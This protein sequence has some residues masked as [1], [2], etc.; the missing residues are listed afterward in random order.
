MSARS[1]GTTG[2]RIERLVKTE[3]GPAIRLLHKRASKSGFHRLFIVSV[4]RRG[5]VMPRTI[6]VVHIL[7]RNATSNSWSPFDTLES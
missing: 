7:E 6:R 5:I 2:R 4:C 1:M 3:F